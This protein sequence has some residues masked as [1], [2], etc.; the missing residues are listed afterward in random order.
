MKATIAKVKQLLKEDAP[1]YKDYPTSG[2]RECIETFL[3]YNQGSLSFTETA[4]RHVGYEYPSP[5][6]EAVD[7]AIGTRREI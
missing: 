1:Y 4:M 5:V 7:E 3:K 6:I 2:I